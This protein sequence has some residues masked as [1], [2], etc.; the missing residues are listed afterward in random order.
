MPVCSGSP[1]CPG[2]HLEVPMKPVNSLSSLSHLHN[3]SV[4]ALFRASHLFSS[5]CDF[6]F[7]VTLHSQICLNCIP[8]CLVCDKLHHTAPNIS[9][10]FRICICTHTGLPLSKAIC[11]PHP[12]YLHNIH[13]CHKASLLGLLDPADE[14]TMAPLKFWGNSTS[15][16]LTPKDLNLHMQCFMQSSANTH[17]VII[18]LYSAVN[19]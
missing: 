4:T 18:I 9:P 1:H 17:W 12:M 10:I 2:G 15:D 6:C 8:D 13:I 11:S 3:Y 5:I 7:I 16:C 14:G 19:R